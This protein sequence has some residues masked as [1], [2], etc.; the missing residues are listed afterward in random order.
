[1]LNCTTSFV[2]ECFF[3]FIF[4]LIYKNWG[5]RISVAPLNI[6]PKISDSNKNKSSFECWDFAFG[7]CSMCV[8][9]SLNSKE[10]LSCLHFR[11]NWIWC[12]FSKYFMTSTV[13]IVK[14]YYGN[15]T[16]QAEMGSYPMGLKVWNMH[17]VPHPVHLLIKKCYWET[18]FPAAAILVH[19]L[20]WL[21]SADGA[22]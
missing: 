9:N 20:V 14:T 16:S 8:P 1:M 5:D 15:V 19:F 11:I 18:E 21:V 3:F 7:C 4:I 2:I 6:I 10:S 12:Q 13:R 17:S 22:S